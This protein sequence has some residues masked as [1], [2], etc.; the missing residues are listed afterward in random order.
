MKVDWDLADLVITPGFD[1][2][3]LWSNQTS[4]QNLDRRTLTPSLSMTYYITKTPIVTG[5]H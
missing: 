3:N 5:K 1:W 4:N 2:F